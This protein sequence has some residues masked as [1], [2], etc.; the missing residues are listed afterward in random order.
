MGSEPGV[1]APRIW[2]NRA[3]APLLQRLYEAILRC[4]RR[5]GTA[6]A[7]IAR[8]SPGHHCRMS[9]IWPGR[10]IPPVAFG[11]LA[12]AGLVL[13]LQAMPAA[14]SLLEYQ[15]TLLAGEPWRL[16]TAHLVHIN[17]THALANAVAWVVLAQLFA[18]QINARR[19]W[20]TI[21]V[22]AA[23]VSGGLAAFY[24]AIEWYRG[25]SGVLHALFF[26]GAT[27]ALLGAL[28]SQPWRVPALPLALLAGGWA[29]VAI[30]L[31]HGA[32]TPYATWLGA[33]TVPQAHL[34]GA[35][36]GTALGLH[37]AVRGSATQATRR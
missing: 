13:G 2:R 20:L 17:W 19:H 24:P 31:P 7:P 26:A 11:A 4:L 12:A 5:D 30:E 8:P 6:E 21:A 27:A 29:K 14:G 25:A 9:L 3:P 18:A 10:R 22:A 23:A 16:L 28:L 32:I 37:F 15:R 36:A 34:L 1:N 35:I 33:T